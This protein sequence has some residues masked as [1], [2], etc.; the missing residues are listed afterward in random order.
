MRPLE[1]HRPATHRGVRIPRS[2]RRGVGVGLYNK[3][4]QLS[5]AMFKEVI[6]FRLLQV[7]RQGA[8]ARAFKPTARS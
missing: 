5:G 2:L 3:P 4:L 8:L 1:E 6:T 7:Q